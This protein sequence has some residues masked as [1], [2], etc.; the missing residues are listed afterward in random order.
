M[1]AGYFWG[2]ENYF[3]QGM[4]NTLHLIVTSV[5]AK[6][7]LFVFFRGGGDSSLGWEIPVPATLSYLFSVSSP[8]LCFRL[9]RTLCMLFLFPVLIQCMYPEIIYRARGLMCVCM[10][11]HV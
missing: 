4:W 11:N 5:V 2:W 8:V 10:C 1:H 6:G 3:I 7:F 9:L